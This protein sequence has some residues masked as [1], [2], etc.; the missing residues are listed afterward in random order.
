[1]YIHIH[2]HCRQ[3]KVFMS[4]LIWK[5]S[6]KQDVILKT[7]I[8]RQVQVT[9]ASVLMPSSFTSYSEVSLNLCVCVCATLYENTPFKH[10]ILQRL[11]MF[12]FSKLLVVWNFGFEWW[13][14]FWYVQ[15]YYIDKYTEVPVT[16][17]QDTTI[18]LSW[19]RHVTA[20]LFLRVFLSSSGR[21]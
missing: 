6:K 12:L 1:M 14:A 8:S 10:T 19:H 5:S 20:D 18:S 9:S 16:Q 17:V 21:L 3:I 2:G 15:E 13:A 7:I 11:D 4:V